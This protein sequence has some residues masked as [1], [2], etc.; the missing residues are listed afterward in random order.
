[1]LDLC[2]ILDYVLLLIPC[3]YIVYHIFQNGQV[4]S[5]LM[6]HKKMQHFLVRFFM[7]FHVVSSFLLRVLASKTIKYRMQG[8]SYH[9]VLEGYVLPYFRAT[10]M[11]YFAWGSTEVR[12]L[13][14]AFHILA[15][16]LESFP[17]DIYCET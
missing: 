8:T 5:K 6:V 12:K 15:F 1:M 3:F 7:A 14:K 2:C 16:P 11:T 4:T 10:N 13:N 17:L 9:A